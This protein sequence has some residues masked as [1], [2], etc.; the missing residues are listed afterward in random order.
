MPIHQIKDDVIVGG[1]P[2]GSPV[3]VFVQQYS[4]ASV[5]MLEVAKRFGIASTTWT[6]G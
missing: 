6:A 5:A 2:L 4:S 1:S 3:D